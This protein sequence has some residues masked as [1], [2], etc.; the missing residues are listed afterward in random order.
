[1]TDTNKLRI[2][3]WAVHVTDARLLMAATDDPAGTTV[4]QL[5]PAESGLH[6]EV[7]AWQTDED[8]L[9]GVADVTHRE[10]LSE[11]L[12]SALR[13]DRQ[14]QERGIEVLAIFVRLAREVLA[15]GATEWSS[16]TST[17]DDDGVRRLNPLL[18]LTSHLEWLVSVHE[19]QPGISVTAR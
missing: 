2:S 16:S 19:G 10:A 12:F 3:V 18:A 5:P 15:A 7:Y 4:R 1:M 8:V 11:A 17:L 9:G 6:R 13:P 14:P